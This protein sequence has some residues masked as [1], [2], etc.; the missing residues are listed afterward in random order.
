MH[1]ILNAAAIAAAGLIAANGHVEQAQATGFYTIE[2]LSPDGAVK[3]SDSIEN[4]V[5]TLGKNSLLDVGLGGAA[6][7]AFKLG[8]IDNASFT[9]VAAAD[10][11][12]SHAGWIESTAY[13]NASR[14]TPTFNAA[15]TGSK[16]TTATAFTINATATIN[17]CF[18]TDTATKGGATGLLYSCGSFSGG[19]RAVINGDTLN[20]T[21]TASV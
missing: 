11:M 18:L 6:F 7:T 3:W 20:V 1:D 21:Y 13:S 14:P 16:A 9:A 5:C 17:G 8:L 15:A 2:C 12:A 4:V 10:T 19:N